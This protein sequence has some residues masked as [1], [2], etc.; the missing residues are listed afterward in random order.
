[1]AQ[2]FLLDADWN[3]PAN[4]KSG[5]VPAD[6]DDVV[7]PSSLG[8]AVFHA[9]GLVQTGIYLNSLFI[10]PG[11]KH[12]IGRA[13]TEL[14]IGAKLL[15]H[16][17]QGAL[18]CDASLAT[19]SKIDEVR[20]MCQRP[21][22]YCEFDSRAGDLG[23]YDAFKF[24]RGTA[25]LNSTLVFGAS[26]TVEVGHMG[27]PDGDA[28]VTIATNSDTLPTY[29]Q[30]AG[31]CKSGVTITTAN[32]S[33]G[34]FEQED[35]PIVTLNITGGTVIYNHGV[36][37]TVHVLGGILDLTD[38]YQFETGADALT[39]T[40]LFNWTGGT[41]YGQFTQGATPIEGNVVVSNYHDL[42]GRVIPYNPNR[43]AA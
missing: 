19:A 23:T 31:R 33:G 43:R 12:D 15:T 38:I 36:L 35:N 7:V 1:M 5:V 24:L 29:T 34:V 14:V 27:N 41:V 28:N 6:A 22:V 4:W 18:Y 20:M 30:A 26:A 37:T 9:T 13:G 10:H 32:I 39:I 8:V 11:Y 2:D 25:V 42:G 3:T 40:D 17:G 21:D 16:Q